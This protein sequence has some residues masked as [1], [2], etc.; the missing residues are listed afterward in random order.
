MPFEGRLAACFCAASRPKSLKTRP[1]PADATCF[2][3]QTVPI[4]VIFFGFSLATPVRRPG[5]FYP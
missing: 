2:I 1:N 5:G 3:L 4:Q